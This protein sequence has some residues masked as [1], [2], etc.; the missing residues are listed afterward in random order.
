MND[1]KLPVG[2]IFARR[3][4]VDAPLA[5]GGMGD[6]YEVTHI[7]TGRKRAL[8]TMSPELLQH[9]GLR[10]R[11][12]QEWRL[13]SK[14]DSRFVVDVYDAGVDEVSSMPFLVMD[15]LRGEHLKQRL[16]RKSRL[17]FPEVVL[18]LSQVALALE[19]S[20]A[21][22]IIHRDLKPENL[23][24]TKRDDG[25]PEIKVLDFG[26]AKLMDGE[27]AS[28][29]ITQVLG[30]PIYMAP[31]QF[32]GR[33]RPGPQTDIYALALIAY[34]LLVGDTYW[35]PE[36]EKTPNRLAVAPLLAQGPSESPVL[37]A[38]S[39][40]VQLPDAFD[41][42]FFRTAH[43]SVL[44][45]EKSAVAAIGLLADALG[46]PRPRTEM[47]SAQSEQWME[48]QQKTELMKM[49]RSDR[50]VPIRPPMTPR[51]PGKTWGR[52]GTFVRLG[53]FTVAA[54]LVGILLGKWMWDAFRS[55]AAPRSESASASAPPAPTLQSPSDSTAP[56]AS[57]EDA[58]PE[59]DSGSPGASAESTA[60]A[61]LTK[62]VP[63]AWSDNRRKLLSRD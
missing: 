38:R 9:P 49:G 45:R 46:V 48:G 62:R 20:H 22:G 54:L 5:Q 51:P 24:L 39:R 53:L 32:D 25:S 42:W 37:R 10:E 17:A 57:A 30:T 23:F 2:C 16:R 61:P 59:V 18:L 43:P 55:R 33:Q 7:A 31:E 50:E 26:I 28:P 56:P 15:L 19:K 1:H 8:K 34:T 27:V 21:I 12:E 29:T 14:I 47:L 44:E 6:I 13:A 4:R 3:Y 40:G 41:T 11:F 52:R 60:A 58:P 36:L 63:P 35:R